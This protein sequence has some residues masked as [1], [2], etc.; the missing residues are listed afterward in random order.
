MTNLLARKTSVCSCLAR[1]CLHL[2]S[3]TL[4][5]AEELWK[6]S[7]SLQIKIDAFTRTLPSIKSFDLSCLPSA[8]SSTSSTYSSYL[9]DLTSPNHPK[10]AVRHTLLLVYSFCWG[11]KIHLQNAL[12]TR[13]NAS[14]RIAQELVSF[15]REL[16]PL[17]PRMNY[18]CAMVGL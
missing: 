16:G 11:A 7:Q 14:V 10:A 6:I 5:T 3:T 12:A 15:L 2:P 4:E 1:T 17:D 18:L 9:N 13:S 8:S